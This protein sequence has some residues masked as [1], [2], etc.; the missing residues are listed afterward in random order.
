M[1]SFPCL[2][3]APSLAICYVDQDD[4]KLT[5]VPL[6]LLP[7]AGIKWFC[8]HT[9]LYKT[10]LMNLGE[11]ISKPLSATKMCLPLKSEKNIK[12]ICAQV[13]HIF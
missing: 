3:N 13:N 2:K 7:S 10:F 1:T 9:W 6:P 12:Q 11:T 4:L 8:H 5:E